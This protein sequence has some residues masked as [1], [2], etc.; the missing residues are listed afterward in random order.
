MPESLEN[1]SKYSSFFV[2]NSKQEST[3]VKLEKVPS[4][5]INAVSLCIPKL[6]I[7]K[8]ARQTNI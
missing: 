3:R 8:L 2:N 6:I 7:P 5:T 1:Q 4:K